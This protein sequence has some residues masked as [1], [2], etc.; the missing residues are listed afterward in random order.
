M[1]AA[2]ET[3]GA[4]RLLAT[5][6]S[7]PKDELT[8]AGA[9]P[10]LLEAWIAAQE[11]HWDETLRILGPAARRGSEVGF[12]DD[13][14]GRVTLRWLA[15]K[16]FEKLGHADSAAAYLEM[17]LSPLG[18]VDQE[19]LTRG[20]AFSFAHRQLVLLYARLGR[21]ED[22]RRHWE[23]LSASFTRPDLELKPLIE[24][25]RA[26]LASAEAMDRSARQ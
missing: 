26:A 16:A 19:Y 15:A 8:R 14:A 21:L 17:V 10:E 18:R 12:G 9:D 11:G 2:G 4:R 20:I 5:V 6:R 1:A 24:E 3:S 13:R 23:I 22:A 7:R 25:T